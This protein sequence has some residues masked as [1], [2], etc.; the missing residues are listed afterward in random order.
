MVSFR[1][2]FQFSLAT[3]KSTSYGNPNIQ[4]GN[5]NETEVS[6]TL[7]IQCG[8]L[9][10]PLDYTEPTSNAKLTLQLAKVPA[11]S[12]PSKGSILLNFGGPGETGRDS[13]GLLA[14]LLQP[15]SGSHYDLIAFDPRGTGNTI[16]FSCVNNELDMATLVSEFVLGNSSDVALG[17]LWARGA[18]DA[19][20]CFSMSN[21][22]GGLIGT[23]FVA[24][25]LISVVDA[26]GEDGMLRY[27]GF[28]YGTT[29]GATVASMFPERID[30]MILDGVQNPHQYY[31]SL[32][33]FEEW[34]ISDLVFSG[35]FSSCVAA[36]DNCSLAHENKTAAEL[37]QAVW[38]LM[39]R[40]KYHPIPFGNFLLDYSTLKSVIVQSMYSTSSWPTL[41]SLLDAL[42]TGNTS[43]ESAILISL[44]TSTAGSSEQTLQATIGIHCGDRSVRASLFDD[45]LPTIDRLYNTS[46]IMGDVTPALSMICAQWKMDAKGRYEGD[47]QVKTKNPALL[48]GNTFDGFTPLA[49]AYNVSSGLEGSVVLEVNGYGHSSISLPSACTLKNTAAYWLNGTLPKPGTVCQVDSPPYSNITWADVLAKASGNTTRLNKRDTYAL[50]MF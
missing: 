8:N 16:S 47:F 17:R 4:W 24:R 11:L 14:S 31:H 28:S 34:T 49:S 35:I 19:N 42:L 12:Q 33:D 18:I 44:I 15:L 41:A 1:T 37:E 10:V 30:K 22:T 21:E 13:L 43:A 32:A 9:D 20:L 48:I 50:P 26:L 5:C 25:D 39:E 2:I 46:R 7:P 40:V 23:A 36:P 6:S 3:A 27:W 45:M 29:L 38:S